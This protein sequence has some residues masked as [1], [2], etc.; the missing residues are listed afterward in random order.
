MAQKVRLAGQ[1]AEERFCKSREKEGSTVE[2]FKHSRV[3]NSMHAV[4]GQM[5]YIFLCT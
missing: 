2:S 5:V 3:Q 1:I 4:D